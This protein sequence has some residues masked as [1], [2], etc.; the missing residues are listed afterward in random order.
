VIS[1]R[2]GQIRSAFDFDTAA[3]VA[4]LDGAGA[5]KKIG[6]MR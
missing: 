4:A 3:V 5:L 1:I 2:C 6:E